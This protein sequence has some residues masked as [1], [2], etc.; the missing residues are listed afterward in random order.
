MIQIPPTDRLYLKDDYCF[1]ITGT[2]VAI[3]ENMVALDRTCFHPGGG[4]QP[5]DEGTINLPNGETMEAISI[6]SNNESDVLR[7]IC[8]TLPNTKIIDRHV[9]LILNKARRLTIM[10][11]HTALH[12]LNTIALR[13]YN[14]Y[15]T[16]VQI[17]ED[18]SRID[19]KLENFKPSLAVELEE[20]VNK[21]LQ[22]AHPLKSYY[23]ADD[24]FHKR[25]DLLRTLD[26]KPPISYGQVRVVEIQGFD[27]QAYGGTHMH[28]TL[29]VGS[30]T[31]FRT[32]NKGRNNKRFYVRV[33][34][35]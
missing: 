5:P 35:E 32:D 33:T 15:I 14:G 1:E 20:K 8:S 2:A 13:D 34:S 17:G 23:I 3:H 10:R 22:E 11:Y 21:V 28:S 24:E 18:Y 6:Q 19:F 9:H 25:S 31:I 27:A 16:G 26:A 4:G 12:V 7:H 29:D 30:F